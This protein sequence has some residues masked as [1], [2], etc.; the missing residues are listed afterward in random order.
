V[1]EGVEIKR[2]EEEPRKMLWGWGRGSIGLAE[3][4]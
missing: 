4:A 3:I 1:T 2:R